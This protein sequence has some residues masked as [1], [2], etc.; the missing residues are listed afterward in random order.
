MTTDWL[1]E[2]LDPLLFRDGRPFGATSRAASVPLPP[3]SALAGAARTRS[4]IGPDGVFQAERAKDLLQEAVTGPLLVRVN[5]QGHLQ[6]WLFTRPADATV[7]TG[8]GIT[9]SVPLDLGPAVTSATHHSGV[10]PAGPTG[11]IPSGKP[12]SHAAPLWSMSAMMAWLEA[13]GDSA[14]WPQAPTDT[15]ALPVPEPRLHVG[16]EPGR[17]TADDGMLFET[18]GRSWSWFAQD[19]R[20][21]ARIGMVVRTSLA[22][23]PGPSVVG[24]ERRMAVWREVHAKDQQRP[25]IPPAVI[26]SARAGSVRLILATAGHYKAGVPP[27]PDAFHPPGAPKVVSAIRSFIVDRWETTSGWDLARGGPK[28]TRRLAPAGSVFFLELGGND[29]E[30]EQWARAAWLSPLSDDP[31]SARDGFGIALLGAWS[32]KPVSMNHLSLG[33]S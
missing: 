17:Q 5:A 13:P 29:D 4:G 30:R 1:I 32:G 15:E 12:D 8:G 28:G 26:R 20:K 16:I 19:R 11:K 2:A 23:K 27:Q 21:E 3:P 14:P 7:W 25:T 31:Q 10:L 6:D 9:R 33:G 18:E 24:G 22:M